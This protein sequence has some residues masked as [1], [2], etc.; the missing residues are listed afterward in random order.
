ML[1]CIN[2]SVVL[3]API[4]D[5]RKASQR[6]ELNGAETED[7]NA[8]SS[9]NETFEL[10]ENDVGL[11]SDLGENSDDSLPPLMEPLSTGKTKKGS[12][13]PP[14]K[15]ASTSGKS[16]VVE[17]A[18]FTD[19]KLY[20]TWKKLYPKDTTKKMDQYILAVINNVR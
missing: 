12:K 14:K 13:K 4:E 19:D 6:Q 20:K 17:I 10:D 16:Q 8:E 2:V 7:E 11:D 15:D 5:L 18:V 9:L 1:S 3:R